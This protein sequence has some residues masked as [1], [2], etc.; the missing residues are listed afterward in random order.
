M[1]V[2]FYKTSRLTE[3]YLDYNLI[4]FLANFAVKYPG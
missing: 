2:K 3:F 4:E 1:Y